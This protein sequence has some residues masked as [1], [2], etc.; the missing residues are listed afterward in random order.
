MSTKNQTTPVNLLPFQQENVATNQQQIPVPYLAGER[1]IAVRW[2]TPALNEQTK[3]ANS[4]T[5]KS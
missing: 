2:Q 4:A 5:K 1:L 3:Q